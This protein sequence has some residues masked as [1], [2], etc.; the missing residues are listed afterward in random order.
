MQEFDGRC[1]ETNEYE[2]KIIEHFIKD[3]DNPDPKVVSVCHGTLGHNYSSILRLKTFFKNAFLPENYPQSV[4]EDYF[5]YQLWDSC[6]AFASSISGT[7]ATQVNLFRFFL[8]LL[9]TLFPRRF[10]SYDASVV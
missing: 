7:L 2:G 10:T 1:K 5:D 8:L 4:S 9:A 3:S 6:Q